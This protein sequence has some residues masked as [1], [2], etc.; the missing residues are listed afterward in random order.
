MMQK[1]AVEVIELVIKS[2]HNFLADRLLGF[3]I[4]TGRR[5]C[6]SVDHAIDTFPLLSIL[7]QLIDRLQI[8]QSNPALL[9]RGVVAIRAML[10]QKRN[11]FLFQLLLPRGILP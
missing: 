5:H 10:R 6:T 9:F 3:W 8:V 4:I 1:T 11:D 2:V 7:Q